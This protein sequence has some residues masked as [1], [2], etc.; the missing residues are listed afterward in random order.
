MYIE[1]L[2]YWTSR[3][4]WGDKDVYK[5]QHIVISIILTMWLNKNTIPTPAKTV[6]IFTEILSALNFL[7]EV[8]KYCFIATPIMIIKVN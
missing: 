1:Y 3:T 2:Q 5:R 8:I 4:L 6:F 7:N